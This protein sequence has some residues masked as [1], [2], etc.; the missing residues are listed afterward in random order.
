[1]SNT[2]KQ[3]RIRCLMAYDCPKGIGICCHGCDRHEGCSYACWNHPSV[4]GIQESA[5]EEKGFDGG[6]LRELRERAGFTQIQF[7]KM[8][9]TDAHQVRA[10]EE[11]RVVP[12]RKTQERIRAVLGWPP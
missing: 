2:K 9:G 7:A 8:I 10:W 5:Q 11:K 3:K 4:C 6:T 12:Y 1:M